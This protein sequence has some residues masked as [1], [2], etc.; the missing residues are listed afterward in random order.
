MGC[1]VRGNQVVGLA[2]PQVATG[3]EHRFILR[4]G[5]QGVEVLVDGTVLAVD[6]TAIDLGAVFDALIGPEHIGQTEIWKVSSDDDIIR[7]R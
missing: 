1:Y 2:F 3:E 5:K 4:A 6:P 7:A